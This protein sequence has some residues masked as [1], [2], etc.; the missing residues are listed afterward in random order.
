M[1]LIL[2]LQVS[3]CCQIPSEV[4]RLFRR[5]PVEKLSKEGKH[6][7]TMK[8]CR[9]VR[10]RCVNIFLCIAATSGETVLGV[11]FEMQC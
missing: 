8:A 10:K 5:N 2:R 11:S 1:W 7:F 9:A 6:C 4:C 3:P